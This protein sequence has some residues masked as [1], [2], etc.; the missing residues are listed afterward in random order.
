MTG[1]G[2]PKIGGY[3]NKG[4]VG[5]YKFP[6]LEIYKL[7]LDYL[8]KIHE[9][10]NRFPESERFNLK[11]QIE[12]AATSVILNI[13]EGSTG[14]NDT[15]QKR[16]LGLS[17]RSYLETIACLD[18]A[19]RRNYLPENLLREVRDLGHHFFIKLQALRKSLGTLVSSRRSS[20]VDSSVPSPQSSVG[21]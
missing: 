5:R 21:D 1:D 14:Q 3:D 18:I 15:E 9:L 19:E 7:A 2:K 12:R 4:D 20:V 16:F 17:L 8:D 10:S 11:S 6:K 13:A